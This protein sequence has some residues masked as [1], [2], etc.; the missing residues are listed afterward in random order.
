MI[1][2]KEPLT[3]RPGHIYVAKTEVGTFALWHQPLYSRGRKL[4]SK[5]WVLYVDSRAVN[6][7]ARYRLCDAKSFAKT[8]LTEQIERRN[9]R[10]RLRI[11]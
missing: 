3:H 6:G 7:S 1:W 11:V 5:T 10:A 2:R 8:H 9:R 4:K